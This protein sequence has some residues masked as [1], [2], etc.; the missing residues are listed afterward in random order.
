[1]NRRP[2]HRPVLPRLILLSLLITTPAS[3]STLPKQQELGRYVTGALN[4]CKANLLRCG[5]AKVCSHAATDAISALQNA[6]QALLDEKLDPITA[7][8]AVAWPPA[9][10]A[11]CKALDIA[12]AKSAPAPA[13]APVRKAVP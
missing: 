8:Q 11:Q 12:P 1:M 13:A 3:C 6:R 4:A 9:A 10:L 2:A 7:A 5:A